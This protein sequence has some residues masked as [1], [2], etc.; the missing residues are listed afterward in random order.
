MENNTEVFTSG[1][2]QES[3]NLK[4]V[5]LPQ[6][7]C[8]Q[9][10]SLTPYGLQEARRQLCLPTSRVVKSFQGMLESRMGMERRNYKSEAQGTQNYPSRPEK[11]RDWIK[12]TEPLSRTSNVCLTSIFLSQ[13]YLQHWRDSIFLLLNHLVLIL[14]SEEFNRRRLPQWLSFHVK[15][16]SENIPESSGFTLPRRICEK[17]WPSTQ[18]AG[19]SQRLPLQEMYIIKIECCSMN[20]IHTCPLGLFIRN[21]YLCLLSQEHIFYRVH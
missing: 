9:I 15:M 7:M 2:H 17:N 4:V 21:N 11:L 18:P 3:Q 8:Y 20:F 6:V 1:A 12:S 5:S 10:P 13:S 14:W 16:S 19:T